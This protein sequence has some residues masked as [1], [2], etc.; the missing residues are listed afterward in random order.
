MTR[1][2]S[3]TMI[4]ITH[5]I[6]YVKDGIRYITG[7]E[8]VFCPDCGC[9]MKLHG[10][11]RRYV[12]RSN[13]YREKLALRVLHCE[14]CQRYHRELP[15]FVVPYKHLCAE[16]FAAIHDALN[17]YCVDDHTAARVCRWIKDFFRIGAAT[18]RRLRLEHPTLV[19]NYDAFSTLEKLKYFV[20][21]VVNVGEWHPTS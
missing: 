9:L 7:D 3:L 18:V 2:S 4:S 21:L 19:T 16:I 1:L 5:F 13:G 15:D 17:N 20:R 6:E 8:E 12:R 14:K 10:R 11:C